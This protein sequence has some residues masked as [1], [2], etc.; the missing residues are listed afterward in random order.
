MPAATTFLAA[1]AVT[2][3]AVSVYSAFNQ[4]KPPDIPAAPAPSSYNSYEYD[5]E[6]NVVSGGSQVWDAAT[7]SYIYKPR[8]LTATEKQEITTKKEIKTKL[9]DNLNKTPAEW[10]TA[11]D[12][13]AK[14]FASV[15]QKTYDESLD[16]YTK[17]QE[18]RL[19]AQGLFG[20]K[21]Y[22]DIEADIAK[23]KSKATTDIAEKSALARESLLENRQNMTLAELNAIEAGQSSDYTKALQ[24]QN[25]ASAAA[26]Q[27]T[28]AT[29]GAYTA[30]TSNLLSDWQM[31]YAM[32]R[33][34]MATSRD[35]SLGLAFLYGYGTKNPAT[36]KTIQ[37]P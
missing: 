2:L 24:K 36:K 14:T 21:A 8:E 17:S 35:T 5:D 28:A 1:A 33:D 13:Y 23:Q 4:P 16:P 19:S 11:A 30:N 10:E 29:M 25:I 37:L 6:G 34:L 27:G 9:L 22:A 3:A 12:E 31:K 15:M 18:E 26:A 32:N 7:N 20:S